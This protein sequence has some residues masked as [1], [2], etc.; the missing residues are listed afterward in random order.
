M[1]R[2]GHLERVVALAASQLLGRLLKRIL[3]MTVAAIFLLG[4]LYE[5]S[6]A[7][8]LQLSVLYGPVCAR[9]I[10]AAVYAVIVL[11]TLG[12]LLATR[13]KA[14][15]SNEPNPLGP[16]TDKR[17]AMLVE[18]ILLGYAMARKPR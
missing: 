10:V 8:T 16:R 18:S 9:L 12:I 1:N 14:P 13:A 11:C 4:V 2:L 7:G 15:V 6:A 17:I 3:A 5:L